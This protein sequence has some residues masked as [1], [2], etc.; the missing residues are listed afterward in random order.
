VQKVKIILL[1]AWRN[2]WR[3]KRRS[4]LTFMTIA[5]GAALILFMRSLQNGGYTQMIEDSVAPRTG[6]IQIH[7]KGFWENMTLE[8]AFKDDRDLFSRISEME[9]VQRVSK[10][11]STGG[12]LTHEDSS[13][14]CEILGIDPLKEKDIITIHKYI[15]PGGKFLSGEDMDGIVLG[16]ALARVMDVKVGDEVSLVSQGFDGSIAA[17][18]FRV[19]GLFKCPNVQYNR[20][21][22]LISFTA[23]RKVFTMM[24]HVTAYVI[25]VDDI[26]NVESLASRIKEVTD[27][28]YEVMSWDRLNPEILQFIALD[29]SSGH[30]FVFILYLIVAFGILNTIQMSVYERT[31]EFGIMLSIGTG[32]DR[33]FRLVM[34]E[35]FF[36]SALGIALGALIGYG[37]SYYFT[38]HPMDFSEYESEMEMYQMSTLVYYAKIRASDFIRAS[39]IVFILAGI[40]SYFPA[41]RAARLNPVTAM[42]EL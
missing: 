32:P 37:L 3:N 26:D 31:R 8:Y 38:V 17:G 4:I 23:A 41:K 39:F 11:I 22:G 33:I 30:L 18:N 6:H 9:N 27:E 2:V 21:L 16:N 7:E 36:V 1:L 20:T 13:A 34:T 40:F 28:T 19:R 12:L 15:L 24:G 29:K 5:A 42:R 10:R 25:R 14:G 35:A